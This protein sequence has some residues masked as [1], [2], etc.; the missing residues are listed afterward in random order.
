[1][2]DEVRQ[3]PIIQE[4][5]AKQ[6][7]CM[8]AHEQRE[9]DGVLSFFTSGPRHTPFVPMII[10]EANGCRF[11]DLDGNE[12]IDIA[13][14]YG[15]LILGHA[16][17]VVVKAVQEAV[18]RGT[19]VV[20]GHQLEYQLGK[21]IID[22]VACA[23]ACHF[24]NS[25]TEATMQAIKMAR[26]Y[27]GRERIAKFEG[28]YHGTHPDVLVSSNL[29]TERRGPRERP[30]S[31]LDC[32][33]VCRHITDTTIVL[34][35]DHEAAF[36]IIRENAKEL[37]CVI[38]E[39]VG[40][41]WPK[42]NIEFLKEL[43]KV[44]EE[45]NVLLVFDEVVTGFRTCFGGAQDRWDVVPD[46]TTF[47]KIVGGGLPLAAV[48]GRRDIMDVAVTSGDPVEDVKTK[49]HMVGTNVG[50]IVS[51]A[52]GFAQMNYLKENQDTVYPYLKEQGERLADEVSSFARESNLPFRMMGI[53][54]AFIVHFLEDEPE[55]MR[56][57]EENTNLVAGK[58]LGYY[59]RRHG[60][61]MSDSHVAFIST[62]HTPE[63]IDKLISAFK[64]SLTDMRADGF[65]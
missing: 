54:S 64:A 56:Q 21:L 53:E 15:P 22:S 50:N 20:V 42:L 36:D 39:P 59:M 41:G 46:M 35:R 3:L 5:T 6:K 30:E 44:T 23:E 18:T 40:P 14:S 25:G 65:C 55:H 28:G 26:A 17:D 32:P 61:Y 16:P 29:G 57:L 27:T 43:R 47:G 8:E 24:A 62:A 58:L 33:G 12:F 45:A 51:C 4:L 19:S 2:Q 7:K 13:M 49:V 38:L 37:A 11:V 31:V 10:K 9:K 52:A 63:D 34:P 1:M 60:I 48:V